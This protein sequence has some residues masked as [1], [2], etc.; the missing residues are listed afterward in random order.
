MTS[1]SFG[2][3]RVP[4]G[5]RH[6]SGVLG[7]AISDLRADLERAFTS[8]EGDLG[9]EVT[10][11]ASILLSTNP[12]ATDTLT[13]GDDTYEFVA[14]DGAVADDGYIAVE[15]GVDAAATQANLIAGINATYDPDEHPNITNIATTAPALANGT[16]SV[17]A[18]V[19]SDILYIRPALVAGG[20]ALAASPDIALSD[21]LTAVVAWNLANL[22]EGGGVATAGEVQHV[23]TSLTVTTELAAGDV[24][25]VDAPFTIGGFQ[26]VAYTAAGAGSFP[27]AVTA[28]GSTLTIDLTSQAATD[29]VQIHMWS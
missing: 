25:T 14:T 21:A 15:I 3:E 4:A 9:G 22:N 8:L 13:I 7:E 16:E 17:V 12:T 20:T 24:A 27:D 18:S 23:Y 5:F 11:V 6:R 10:P 26:V 1:R 29:I 2:G 19:A 28:S